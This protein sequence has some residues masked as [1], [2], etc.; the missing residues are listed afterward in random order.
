MFG[1]GVSLTHEEWEILWP[2]LSYFSEEFAALM[3]DRSLTNVS[4]I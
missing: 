1:E 4:C 2:K 3:L